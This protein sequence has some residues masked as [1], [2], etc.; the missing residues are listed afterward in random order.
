MFKKIILL[1]IFGLFI[2]PT[3]YSQVVKEKDGKYYENKPYSGKYFEYYENG[4]VKVE[5]SLTNGEED[6]LTFLYF[7]N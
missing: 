5:K 3:I 4:N 1:I 2:S 6:G 7:E